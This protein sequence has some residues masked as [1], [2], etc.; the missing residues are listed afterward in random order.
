MNSI[1]KINYIGTKPDKY[2]YTEELPDNYNKIKIWD[3]KNE[4]II[5]L[6][7]DCVSLYQIIIKF[8][9]QIHLLS[10]VDISKFST[11]PS[12]AMAIYRTKFYDSD[13]NIVKR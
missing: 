5:Y 4:T 12:I 7:N 2:Y 13:M 3:T 8:S 9:N 10:S 1:E 11:L 6:K